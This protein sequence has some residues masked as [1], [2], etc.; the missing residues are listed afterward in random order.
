M[1]K[2]KHSV[3]SK[4]RVTIP[5]HF[6]GVVT[7]AAHTIYTP[8]QSFLPYRRP[9]QSPL[10]SAMRLPTLGGMSRPSSPEWLVT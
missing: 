4:H 1:N 3:G 6:Q 9:L 10:Y 2:I 8:W 5:I 7:T